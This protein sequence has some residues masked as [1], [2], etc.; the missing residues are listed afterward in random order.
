MDRKVHPE[1]YGMKAFDRY[2]AGAYWLAYD[3]CSLLIGE[4]IAYYRDCI[5]TELIKEEG[6]DLINQMLDNDSSLQ[7]V[8]CMAKGQYAGRVLTRKF[9]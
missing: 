5:N 2:V 8:V 4:Q 9:L 3:L 1:V 6:S 7:Y